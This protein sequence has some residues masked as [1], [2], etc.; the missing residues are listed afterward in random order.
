MVELSIDAT[1]RFISPVIF[2]SLIFEF[3]LP[4][5]SGSIRNSAAE[6]VDPGNERLAVGMTLI[7]SLGAEI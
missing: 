7:S 2:Y 4:V 5:T 6:L 1:T 3:R